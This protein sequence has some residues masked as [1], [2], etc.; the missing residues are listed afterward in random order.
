MS[1]EYEK[2]TKEQKALN[3]LA[4]FIITHGN[5]DYYDASAIEWHDILKKS[6]T[7]P[8]ADE[9]RM[10]IENEIEWETQF[11]DNGF[12]FKDTAGYIVKLDDEGRLLFGCHP[13]PYLISLIARFYEAQE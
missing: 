2:L 13:T 1:K 6:L 5:N 8:T 12:Y 7:P 11:R 10:A 9:V 4:N 3:G